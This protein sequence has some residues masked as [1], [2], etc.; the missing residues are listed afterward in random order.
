M[1]PLIF[2]VHVPK[3]AGSTVNDY[4]KEF[5]PNGCDH[6]EAIMGDEETF[7][8]AANDMDWLSGHVD[9]ATAKAQLSKLTD[10]PLRFFTCMRQPD[11]QVMSHYNW[12]IEIFHKGSIFY[13]NHPQVIKEI[14][15]TIRA[16][17]NSVD[18]IIDNLSRFSGLFRNY[19]SRWILGRDFNWNSGNIHQ[20]LDIYEK[21]VD[22]SKIND[23]LS[24]MLGKQVEVTERSNVS[25]Y[26]F[27]IEH[28]Q[29]PEMKRFLRRWN[30]LDDALYW[31]ISRD[32]SHQD[33]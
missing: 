11:Q 20:R 23:L 21:I 18:Q 6:C 27:D 10:R 28:F 29:S 15:E 30:T 17:S 19:Q 16:N 26:H 25:P 32:D 4:L 2:F 13:D 7:R 31:L 12:L 33:Q 24:R 8:R 14:S 5:L 9:I 3:T 22:N 1:K